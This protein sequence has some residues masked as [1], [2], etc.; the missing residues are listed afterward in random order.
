MRQLNQLQFAAMYENLCD[1]ADRSQRSAYSLRHEHL[2][3][4]V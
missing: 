2:Q 3:L 1:K 4:V